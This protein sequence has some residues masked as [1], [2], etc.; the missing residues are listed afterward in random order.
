M[1][2]FID[3]MEA[4]T[5]LTIYVSLFILEFFW[6]NFL[7]VLNLKY[8]RSHSNM[9]PPLISNHIDLKDL[10]QSADYTMVR[11]KFGLLTSIVGSLFILIVVLSGLL[12]KIESLVQHVHIRSY[13]Q[14]ILF[15]Y[16]ISLMLSILSLPFSIYSQFVIEERFGFN[17]MTGRLFFTD[18]LKSIILSII[19]MTPL[20]FVLFW[21]MDKT[22]AYWWV[23]A[24]L[25]ITL[26][27]LI[28]SYLYPIVI[29][30]L[31]NKFLP[32]ED[33]PLKEK[34]IKLTGS[35]NLQFAIKGVFVMDGSKRSRHS[36][37]YFTGLGKY[38]RIVLFD[39]LIHS[40]K[41]NQIVAVLAHEI[42]H[43]KKHHILKGILLSILVTS[44]G[45]WLLSLILNYQPFFTAFGFSSP[46]Y[47]A[48]IVLFVF[49]S[50]PLTFFLKPL[51]SIW[52]RRHEYEADRFAVEAVNKASDLAEAIL[53]LSR[54]N[55]SNLT[56]HPWYSFYYY[57]HPTLMERI[58][59][60]NDYPQDDR[61]MP[62]G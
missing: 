38:K 15:I 62:A 31:F 37:T 12:G 55:L 3:T 2:I 4:G 6:E 41:E 36:N 60:M 40:L 30:P 61:R 35:H 44:I 53:T 28:L 50:G 39:T 22:G 54:E 51:F 49:C 20:L 18:K 13:L 11:T 17:K 5:I 52:S 29:A 7:A 59:A 1:S 24:L 34:I 46:S 9:V 26:F 47:H 48:A 19:I 32:L 27:Q 45:L 58:R 23:W 56:P 10:R 21:F 43:E 8:I 16:T 42:G 14:G 57:S 25:F 33:G